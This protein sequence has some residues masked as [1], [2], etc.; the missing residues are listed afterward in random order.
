MH[1]I[2]LRKITS[3]VLMEHGKNYGIALYVTMKTIFEVMA[4]KIKL[5]QHLFLT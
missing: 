3:M 2:A 5:N 1:L 4:A